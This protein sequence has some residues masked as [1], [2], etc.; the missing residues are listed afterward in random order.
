[1]LPADTLALGAEEALA[2]GLWRAG[3]IDGRCGARVKAVA[4]HEGHV[5]HRAWGKPSLAMLRPGQLNPS[6]ALA[7][8]LQP[9]RDKPLRFAASGDDLSHGN[10]SSSTGSWR[11]LV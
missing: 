6:Q 7:D 4:G 8:A 11:Q 3:G 10:H 2:G 5:G 9:E 1:M